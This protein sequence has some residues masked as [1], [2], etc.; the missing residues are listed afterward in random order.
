MRNLFQTAE[1]L[2]QIFR[3]AVEQEATEKRMHLVRKSEQA[4]R[5]RIEHGESEEL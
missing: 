1:Q 2:E 3:D 5:D 4:T